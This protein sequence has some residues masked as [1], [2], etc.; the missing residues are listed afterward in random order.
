MIIA[1]MVFVYFVGF[2]GGVGWSKHK[3]GGSCPTGPL[4][5]F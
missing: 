3:F 1:K 5:T 4:A 2:F